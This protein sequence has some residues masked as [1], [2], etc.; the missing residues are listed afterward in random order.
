[1]TTIT[2][3]ADP[4][5]SQAE[6]LWTTPVG[7]AFSWLLLLSVL[8]TDSLVLYG[9]VRE[10]SV[11]RGLSTLTAILGWLPSYLAAL[12]MPFMWPALRQRA[13]GRVGRVDFLPE[14]AVGGGTILALEVL[15]ATG[16]LGTFS[17]ADLIAA[18]AGT[19]SAFLLYRLIVRPYP[20]PVGE[21]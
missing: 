21:E 3:S 9:G 8:V 5:S 13:P 19:V 17:W 2:R 11:E 6:V 15:D 18:I 10:M 1:M 12:A 20:T 7:R 14:V 4:R 16:M